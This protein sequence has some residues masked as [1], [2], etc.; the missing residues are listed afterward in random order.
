MI[1]LYFHITCVNAFKAPTA[2]TNMSH[3]FIHFYYLLMLYI[4]NIFFLEKK[5]KNLKIFFKKYL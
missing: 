2:K 1:K 3:N 4:N 5:F